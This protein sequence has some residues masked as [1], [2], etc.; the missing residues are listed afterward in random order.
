LV[1]A[2]RL[3]TRPRLGTVVAAILL[4]GAMVLT[5]KRTFWIA[6]LC[7]L[8]P[9]GMALLATRPHPAVL[10]RRVGGLALAVA[11]ATGLAILVGLNTESFVAR[12]QD[13]AA[14]TEVATYQSREVEWR[15]VFGHVVDR[16]LGHGLGAAPRI[17]R[18]DPAGRPT[19]YIHN[20]YLQWSILA[21]VPA[22]LLL[23]ALLAT[24]GRRLWRLRHDPDALALG[25]GLLAVAVAGLAVQSFQAPMA[26][27][28][29]ALAASRTEDPRDEANPASG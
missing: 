5:Y 13:L 27:V 4:G 25:A 29:L 16:P 19:H 26:T 22:A 8:I 11:A 20:T 28:F 21:G 23:L 12:T 17:P 10:V 1:A 9:V 15:E 14:P 7:G 24:L 3:L 6:S 2:T 18:H